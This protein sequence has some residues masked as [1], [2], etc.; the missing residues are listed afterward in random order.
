MGSRCAPNGHGRQ[1]SYRYAR[2][3]SLHRPQRPFHTVL[4]FLASSLTEEIPTGIDTY[5]SDGG[6]YEGGVPSGSN[7]REMKCCMHRPFTTAVP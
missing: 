1:K 7:A 3:R 2:L 6:P 5:V 4:H